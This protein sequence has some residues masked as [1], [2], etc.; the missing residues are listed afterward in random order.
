MPKAFNIKV[1]KQIRRT[2]SLTCKEGEIWMA[3]Y[4]V[5]NS[6]INNMHNF[7]H[8]HKVKIWSFLRFDYIGESEF[9]LGVYKS[10]GLETNYRGDISNSC[11]IKQERFEESEYIVGEDETERE[12]ALAQLGFSYNRNGQMYYKCLITNSNVCKKMEKN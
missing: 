11:L 1:G 8:Q 3:E 5:E 10:Y 9:R 7:M 2:I 4:D 12:K 6:R